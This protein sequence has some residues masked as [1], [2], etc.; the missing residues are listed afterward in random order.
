MDFCLFLRTLVKR[1]SHIGQKCSAVL[2]NLRCTCPEDFGRKNPRKKSPSNFFWLWAESFQ[3]F[4]EYFSTCFSQSSF[5]ISRALLESKNVS[6]K[7]EFITFFFEFWA[8]G[9]RIWG[10]IV[11]AV[12][13][14]LPPRYPV[15]NFGGFCLSK[16]LIFYFYSVFE[17]KHFVLW[18]NFFSNILETTCHFRGRIFV[19]FFGTYCDLWGC[20]NLSNFVWI[21]WQ[22]HHSTSP[23]FCWRTKF[24]WKKTNVFLFL[25][26]WGQR[27]SHIGQKQSCSFLELALYEVQDN[28]LEEFFLWKN[29]FFYFFSEFERSIVRL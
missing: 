10:K 28:S 23:E 2:S 1:F 7:K 25:C 13:S 16:I 3:T 18:V 6:G 11:E 15:R 9:F 19:D 27:I 20:Q 21:V 24:L 22:K 12:I 14:K 5:F 4:T 17:R 29:F 8:E 26:T